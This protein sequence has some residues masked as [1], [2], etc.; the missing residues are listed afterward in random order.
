MLF[1]PVLEPQGLRVM[2]VTLLTMMAEMPVML[3]MLM[4]AMTKE[5]YEDDK[6]DYDDDD[7]HADDRNNDHD[8]DVEI[9]RLGSYRIPKRILLWA[10]E[11]FL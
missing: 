5:F 11:D 9:R 6:Y 1:L 3:M 10:L 4:M 8:D 2:V 7:D